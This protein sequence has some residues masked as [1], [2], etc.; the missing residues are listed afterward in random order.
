MSRSVATISIYPA[1]GRTHSSALQLS[2]L[3]GY[4]RS[5][6]QAL[7]DAD[8]QRHV[9]I[10]NIK[11]EGRSVFH[12]G[13][14]EVHES[15][16]KG[17]VAY[18]WQIL[19]A[20]RRIPGLRLV[21]LQHEF[22]QFGGVATVALIPVLLWS[23]RFLLRVKVVVTYHEVV[24][25]ELLNPE[26][27]DNFCLPV[28]QWAARHLFRWYYRVT[29]FPV[30]LVLVQ[31]V[32][33]RDVLRD[34]MKLRKKISILPIGTETKACLVDRAASRQRFGIGAGERVLLF[35][36]TQDWRKGLHLLVEAFNSLPSSGYRLFIGGGQSVRVKHH[37]RF[38][39]WYSGVAAAIAGNPAIVQVGFVAD[40]DI[41][42][43]FAASDLVV[44]PFVVPQ[45]V[46]AVLNQAASYE[47]PFIVSEA[48]GGAFNSVVTFRAEAS[49]LHDKIAWCFSD[50][51]AEEL[52]EHARR[53]K[54]ENSWTRSA[55]LLSTYYAD[56]LEAA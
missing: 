31:H 39:A 19:R 28:P 30:D 51:H 35:F 40:E 7:P 50:G 11:D 52:R 44:L 26:M 22:N 16:S 43:L 41:P 3:A 21:H 48:F 13:E 5:L 15:W 27:S 25:R 33:F 6:L 37:P 2:A 32:K 1:R 12:D 29:S 23:L 55:D 4:T 18:V 20:V 53:Y 9:V 14:I 34:E 17:S 54:H 56:V 24:G 38:K 49:S 42:A 46:S 36:G 8:R 10:T 45:T 47:R